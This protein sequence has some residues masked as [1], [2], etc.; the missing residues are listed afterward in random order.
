MTVV[1]SLFAVLMMFSTDSGSGRVK[2]QGKH[3]KGMFGWDLERPGTDVCA[4]DLWNMEKGRCDVVTHELSSLNS[5]EKAAFSVR[6]LHAL[7]PLNHTSINL[8][9]GSMETGAHR[10]RS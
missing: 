2:A 10:I 4:E 8:Q 1:M 7:S 9:Q 3:T 5:P 6:T